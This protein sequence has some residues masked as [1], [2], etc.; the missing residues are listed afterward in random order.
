MP[1]ITKDFFLPKTS[2]KYPEG[3]SS[4]TTIIAKND[5]NNIICVKLNPF[6]CQNR[7]MIGRKNANPENI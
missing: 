4:N 6:S 3:T 5:C 7:T 2:A 1:A